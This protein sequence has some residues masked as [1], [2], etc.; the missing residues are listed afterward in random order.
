MQLLEDEI[1]VTVTTKRSKIRAKTFC[2]Q[3]T[4]K[5]TNKHDAMFANKIDIQSQGNLKETIRGSMSPSYR[6]LKF[7]FLSRLSNLFEQIGRSQK[8][9]LI[10]RK[11]S[12]CLRKPQRTSPSWTFLHLI[13]IMCS[14][15]TVFGASTEP[16]GIQVD[17]DDGGYTGIVF[18]IKDDVPEES[19]AEILQN[20]QVGHL[21]SEQKFRKAVMLILT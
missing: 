1:M 7:P 15:L 2:M 20:L 17:P 14:L 18:E 16:S 6:C 9:E 5:R 11:R 12:E 3:T 13:Y 8:S 10:L 21:L 4:T 19:C